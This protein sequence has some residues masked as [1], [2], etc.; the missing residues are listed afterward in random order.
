MGLN[1]HF[2]SFILIVVGHND[3]YHRIVI[4]KLAEL[5]QALFGIFLKAVTNHGLF[6]NVIDG[7]DGHSLLVWYEDR[8]P[9]LLAILYQ[10][11]KKFAIETMQFC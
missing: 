1:G 2:N 8:F 6:A 9:F 10:A 4:K 7:H 11:D 3:I 5:L